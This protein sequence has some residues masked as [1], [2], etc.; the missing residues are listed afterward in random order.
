MIIKEA[1]DHNT[2]GSHHTDGIITEN[3]SRRKEFIGLVDSSSVM[4]NASTFC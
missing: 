2:F 1:I 3:A 4:V